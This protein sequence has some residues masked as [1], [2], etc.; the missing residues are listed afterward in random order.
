MQTGSLSIFEKEKQQAIAK[1]NTKNW[2]EAKVLCQRL[3]KVN[4]TDPEVW[5]LLSAINGQLGKYGEA[6][7][8]AQKAVLLAPHYSDA[9][10]NLALSFLSTNRINEGISCL[11]RLLQIYPDDV[12]VLVTLGDTLLQNDEPYNAIDSFQRALLYEPE[13]VSALHGIGKAYERTHQLAE[14]RQVAEKALR[15]SPAHPGT[16]LLIARLDRRAGDYQTARSRLEKLLQYCSASKEYMQITNETGIVLDLIGEYKQAFY[17]FQASQNIAKSQ[18]EG[19]YKGGRLLARIAENRGALRS[20][21]V[22]ASLNIT[23]KD[24]LPDPIFLV[25]FP[26]SGTTLLEQILRSHSKIATA[27]EQPIL[28]G[29][30]NEVSGMRHHR[31]NY[32]YLLADLTSSDIAMLREH[33][34][35]RVQNI[36]A[37]EDCNKR[38]LDKVPLNIIEMG[39]VHRL[40]PGAMII[41]AL[42]DPRDVCISCFFQLFTPNNAMENFTKLGSTVKL[43]AETM[44]LWLEYQRVLDLNYYEIRYE[45]IIS[46]TGQVIRAL[47]DFLGLEWEEDILEYYSRD[48]QRYVSTPS[49]QDVTVPIYT[50][51]VGRWKNYETQLQPYLHQLQPYL[52]IFGY[53]Y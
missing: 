42:R 17:W 33:Y 48:K 12:T 3:C 19:I 14:S 26:R 53:H 2:V 10:Y 47:L 21:A 38:Y 32:P 16:N 18:Y 9:H 28:Q 44:G 8:C 29:L 1:F 22:A 6:I 30:I 45:E 4:D 31:S 11:N 50:R 24:D 20:Q 41:L 51:A 43:Y 15:I 35:Q 7:D 36:L 25:G 52:D 49:Y 23:H 37:P 34:W 5:C 27:D 13:N 46:N 39:L 40:F